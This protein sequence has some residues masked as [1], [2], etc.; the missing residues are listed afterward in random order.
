V[1]ERGDERASGF[2]SRAANLGLY[3]RLVGRDARPLLAQ[4]KLVAR[5]RPRF[6]AK[7]INV[8]LT[9]V[10]AILKG[11]RAITPD[12]GLRLDR[13]FGLSEGWWFAAQTH[14][15]M[16]EAQRRFGAAIYREV[17]PREEA[18]VEA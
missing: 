6:H 4:R 15:D 16:R 12:T 1:R 2:F 18:L 14:C 8:P 10:T 9:R 5:Q 7:D 3:R 17:A 11:A 13:Y